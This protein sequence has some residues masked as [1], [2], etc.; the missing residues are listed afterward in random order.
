MAGILAATLVTG[1]MS[2]AG[3]AS[4]SAQAPIVLKPPWNCSSGALEVKF[5]PALTLNGT[6]KKTTFKVTGHAANCK[7]NPATPQ[8][9]EAEIT[10][11]TGTLPNNSCALLVPNNANTAPAMTNGE[12]TWADNGNNTFVPSSNISFPAGDIITLSPKNK[13]ELRWTGK[14]QGM[15]GMGSLAGKLYLKTETVLSQA[16]LA[17]KCGAP[18][19][20]EAVSLKGSDH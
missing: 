13:I 1:I 15:I 20:L 18:K 2:Y 19:G 6:G 14:Q 7:E 10:R 5:K 17:A 3:A 11:F 8:S 4:A 12:F 16:Q 9:T